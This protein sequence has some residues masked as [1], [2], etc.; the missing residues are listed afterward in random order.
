[1]A[2]PRLFTSR[3]EILRFHARRELLRGPLALVKQH[4]R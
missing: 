1:M 4:L 2:T 3:L